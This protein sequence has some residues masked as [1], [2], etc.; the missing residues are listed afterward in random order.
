GTLIDG[1]LATGAEI[2]IVPGA[3]RGRLRTLQSHRDTVE[4]ALPGTR[5]AVNVSGIAKDELRRGMVL[6]TPGWLQAATAIDVELR[7]VHDLAHPV[8]HN[9]KVTFHCAADEANAQ[10]RL[11]DADQLHGGDV[12]WAQLRLETPVALVRGD[13]FVVRTPNDTIGGGIIVDVAPKRHR[14]RDQRAIAALESRL[15]DDPEERVEAIVA[16]RKLV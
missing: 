10:V 3:L 1:T 4:C 8:R 11:L 13:R 7:A 2:E 6:T 14:R 15:S 9:M 16:R 5:T 12:A